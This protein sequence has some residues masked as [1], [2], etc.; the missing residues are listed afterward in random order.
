M[1]IKDIIAGIGFM[2]FLIGASADLEYSDLRIVA[3]M[4]FGGLFLFWF[5]AKDYEET[6]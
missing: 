2:S 5:F 6:E 1:K 4:V 3:V